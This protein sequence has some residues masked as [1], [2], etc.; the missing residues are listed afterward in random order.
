MADIT[1]CEGNLTIDPWGEERYQEFQ[2]YFMTPPIEDGE[3]KYFIS[4]EG[5]ENGDKTKM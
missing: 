5:E 2:S 3:C 4:N 1:M